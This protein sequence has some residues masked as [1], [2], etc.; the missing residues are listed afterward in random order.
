MGMHSQ[1][2][3]FYLADNA[4]CAI[5]YYYE[6]DLNILRLSVLCIPYLMLY[7]IISS[8]SITLYI[9][10]NYVHHVYIYTSVRNVSR[11]L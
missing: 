11:N 4:Y 5:L 1:N 7:G 6:F 10:A 2:A 9:N 3:G 8:T